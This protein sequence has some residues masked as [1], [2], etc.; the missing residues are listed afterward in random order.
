MTAMQKDPRVIQKYNE[1]LQASSLQGKANLTKT[2][3]ILY[4][5]SNRTISYQP[6]RKQSEIDED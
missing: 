5:D 4:A 2:E 3:P 1:H 6:S